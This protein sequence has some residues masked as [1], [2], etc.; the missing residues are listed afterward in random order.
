[1][2]R[3]KAKTSLNSSDRANEQPQTVKNLSKDPQ[4]VDQSHF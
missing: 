2:P 3:G 4:L 1:M